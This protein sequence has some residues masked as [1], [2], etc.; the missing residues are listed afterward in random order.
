MKKFYK[1]LVVLAFLAASAQAVELK[2]FDLQS[3]GDK[4]IINDYAPTLRWRDAGKDAVDHYEVWINGKKVADT[5]ENSYSAGNSIG[6]GETSWHVVAVGNDGKKISSKSKFTFKKQSILT[7]RWGEQ[8]TP[9]NVHPEYP[10]PQMV[11]ERWEH[12]NGLWDYSLEPLDVTEA[13]KTFDGKIL[14]PFPLESGLSGVMVTLGYTNNIWYSRTFE[15][16]KAWK[17]DRIILHFEAVDYQTTVWVNGKKVGEHEGGYDPFSFDITDALKRKGSQKLV[18]KVVDPTRSGT[19][20]FGKQVS[21]EWAIKIHSIFTATSGIWLPVWIEPV[22]ENHIKSLRMVPDID[23]EILEVTPVCSGDK[24]IVELVARDGDKVVA[25][26]SG[27]PGEK[28]TLSIKEPRLWSPITPFLYDLE[29]TLKDSSS[30]A[31]KVESY[32]G[33]RKISLGKVGGISKIFLNNDELFLQEPLDQGY[34]P[35]GT[36]THPTDEALRWDVELTKYMGYNGTRKHIK[37]EPRRWYYW[38]DKL[39]LL[40]QQ[41]MVSPGRDEFKKDKTKR[42]AQQFENDLRAMID[43][44]YSVPSIYAWVIFNEGWG[45]HDTERYTK[46]VREL[47]PDRLTQEFSGWSDKGGGDIVDTHDYGHKPKAPNAEANRASM[48]GEYGAR[49]LNVEGHRTWPS[50]MWSGMVDNY[51]QM[52]ENYLHML[53]CVDELKKIK[54]I[55]GAVYSVLTDEEGENCGLVTYDREVFKV[56]P[57]KVIKPSKDLWF[58]PSEFTYK[59]IDVPKTVVPGELFNVTVHA[60][61]KN[62]KTAM[63]VIDVYVDG[64]KVVSDDS[65]VPTGG[66]QIIDIPLAISK[67]GKHE[68]KIGD[69][70]AKLTVS[71][72]GGLIDFS[73]WNGEKTK[74][75]VAYVD[76]LRVRYPYPEK[77]IAVKAAPFEGSWTSSTYEI[78]K[79]VEFS[80]LEYYT[81]IVEGEEVIAVVTTDSGKTDEI[82]LTNGKGEIPLKIKGEKV[83]VKLTL[84]TDNQKMHAPEVIELKLKFE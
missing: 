40:V 62:G 37:V 44:L 21:R 49:G 79:K 81:R 15:V 26:G 63:G 24:G 72:S 73:G 74:D 43:N 51:Y 48:L 70:T 50:R 83:H 17:K 39:G 65:W 60:V 25:K 9:E 57:A 58:I 10:R 75:V 12:L 69:Q 2:P 53:G 61:N 29:A 38:A 45:Q 6:N 11:R 14:V 52:T 7:T 82:K 55:S 13:P 31:D 28:I 5:K 67:I 64:E 27:K 33:M 47:D 54:N 56:D 4:K 84:K 20:P 3:P 68:I 66:S 19:Q 16:S 32:F 59:S 22:P 77:G 78:G 8:V 80:A 35:E 18:V 41:D 46:L 30:T 42:P 23:K 34:W 1:H 36:L 71:D 76:I